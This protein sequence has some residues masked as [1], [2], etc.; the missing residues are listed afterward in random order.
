MTQSTSLLRVFAALT[1]LTLPLE[2]L[3]EDVDCRNCHGVTKSASVVDLNM[4]YANPAAH[5]PVGKGFPAMD[6]SFHRPMAQ[7]GDIAFFDRNANGQPDR[8]EIQLFGSGAAAV[9]SCSTCHAEH[10]T[11]HALQRK[12]PMYLRVANTDSGLC[13]T[14]HNQ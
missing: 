4:I 10:G 5:H 13:S 3:A 8:D 12:L 6:D 2:I 1:L 9:I 14:C 11:T 7:L